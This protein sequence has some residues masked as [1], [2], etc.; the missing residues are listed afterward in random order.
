[1]FKNIMVPL[2][3]SEMAERAL[4]HATYLATMSSGTLHLVFVVEPPSAVRAHG[5]GAPVNVYQEI[6]AAQRQEAG[7][8]LEHVSGRLREEGQTVSGQVLDGSA[9]DALL[10]CVRTG[11]VDLVVMTK[12]GREGVRRWAMGTVADRVTQG[13]N[14]AVL[15]VPAVD[16]D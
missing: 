14:V 4:S 11:G 7:A 16:S 8:Y 5:L 6:I 12:H 3:G 1:M 15:L 13:S 2:D 9:A 10:D